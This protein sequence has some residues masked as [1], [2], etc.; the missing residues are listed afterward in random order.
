MPLRKYTLRRRIFLSMIFLVIIASV[1]IAAITIYQYR[2]QA[3]DY[4]KRRL[5][6]KEDA[7]KSA[8][9]YELNR[10]GDVKNFKKILSRKIDEISDIHNLDIN[11][12]D[13][14]GNL[15]ISSNIKLNEPHLK[16]LTPYILNQIRTK[17]DH[18]IV[19]PVTSPD[20]R[21]FYS[22]YSFIYDQENNPLVII[23]VPY[24]Q[25]NTFQEEEL[26]EFL[27][28][29]ALVYLLIFI[30]AIGLAYF[31]SKYVTKPI[32]FVSSRIRQTT[33]DKSNKKINL[34]LAS[35]E[36]HALVN[37]YNNM[38]DQ[39]KESA[40]KL[41]EVERK[42]AWREM[43]KQV[44]HEIKNPL[45]PMRLT[46]QSFE[47]N[48]DPDDPEIREKVRDLSKSLIQQIDT[49]DSIASTF[50]TFAKMPV[51]KKEVFNLSDEIRYTLQIFNRDFI[52]F[53]TDNPELLVRFDKVQ[54]NRLITNLVK[55]AVQAVASVEKPQVEVILSDKGNHVEILV[56]DNGE[57]IEKSHLS[58]I[59]EPKFTTKSSGMGLGLPMVKNIVE[60]YNGSITVTS[61]PGK[62]TTFKIIL[63]KD[64]NI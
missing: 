23:G 30:I 40:S 34:N 25:D 61:E 31:L 2:E 24:L 28:R 41:A 54:I 38:V 4:H 45:T 21:Q 55:N 5:L 58:K 14:A 15:I 56:K 50:S 13:L 63:P 32:E 51:Q 46:I 19:L 59:F 8:M 26:E 3:N 48:F 12:Y 18:R 39:L 36:M 29:L 64:L 11:I 7:I 16:K 44:A 49:M 17:T 53:S 57:G 9:Y 43:A 33:L 37:S 20:G 6:R 1:L 35:K 62:G 10:D 42:H 60:A 47:Q 27:G 22:S 52:R